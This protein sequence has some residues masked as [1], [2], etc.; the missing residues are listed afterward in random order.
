MGDILSQGRDRGPRR[1]TLPLA[2]AAAGVAL[3]VLAGVLVHGLLEPRARHVSG[4]QATRP[5]TAQPSP[6]PAVTE[7]LTQGA[8]PVRPEPVGLAGVP[9]ALDSGVRLLLTGAQ[10][11]WFWPATGRFEP[12]AGLPE[13]GPGYGFTRVAGGWAAQGYSL[14]TPS[15][16]TCAGQPSPVYFIADGQARAT[17]VGVASEVAAAGR[18]GALWL[19]TDRPGADISVT[20]GIAQEVTLAGRPIGPRVHLPAGYVIDRAVG[21]ALLLTPLL[22]PYP[23]GPGVVTDEL[24]DPGTGRIIREFANVIAASPE[25]IAWNPCGAQCPVYVLSLATGT[26]TSIPLAPG[27]WAVG[28]T[29]SSDG[30]LLAVQVSAA[31]TPDGYAA[32]NRLEVIDIASQHLTAVPGTTISSR[33]GLSFGWQPGRDRLLAAVAGA[34]IVVHVASWQPGDSYLSIQA[35]RIPRGTVLVLGDSG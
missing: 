28:G 19:T 29:F 5:P 17:R 12:I 10:P 30:R 18:G 26:S 4:A 9:V 27:T 3:L 21:G 20:S 31:V 2:L 11:D 16:Q 6:A 1:R 24:W 35:A 32:A 23:Q 13:S 7:G 8:R 22:T 33:V 34:S 25:Q 14:P 15:C